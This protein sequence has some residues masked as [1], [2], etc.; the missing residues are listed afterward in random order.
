MT[1]YT[2]IYIYLQLHTYDRYG[3]FYRHVEMNS[4]Y[5]MLHGYSMLPKT[6]PTTNTTPT[7][8]LNERSL[9]ERLKMFACGWM[10]HAP[11]C[12]PLWISVCFGDGWEMDRNKHTT[13]HLGLFFSI[14]FLPNLPSLLATNI[15]DLK[16]SHLPKPP[17][18][19]ELK[20]LM[21]HTIVRHRAMFIDVLMDLK[22][23]KLWS[24]VAMAMEPAP[25]TFYRKLPQ[26]SIGSG[27]GG[28][29]V[30]ASPFW[31]KFTYVYLWKKGWTGCVGWY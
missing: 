11:R 14:M 4:L 7:L 15:N 16:F 24:R 9:I 18:K 13:D 10:F 23:V 3:L 1:I 27:T 25:G 29:W 28:E 20:E 26:R 21:K 6:Y 2:Y 22:D 12:S 30:K 8:M 19:C 31:E 5:I 17:L